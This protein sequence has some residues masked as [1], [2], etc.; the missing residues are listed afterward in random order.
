[1]KPLLLPVC[2]FLFITAYAQSSDFIVVKKNGQNFKSFFKGAYATFQI[3]KNEWIASR[4]ADIKN[5]SIF[6]REVMVRQVATPWGVPKLDTMTTSLRKIHYHDITAVP[7]RNESF[8]FIKDGTLLMMG[9]GGYMLLNIV[10]G[11]YLHYA[12][13]G[14]ENLP[15]LLVATGVFGT[16][17]LLKKLRKPYLLTGKKYRVEYIRMNNE[18]AVLQ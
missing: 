3:N 5:D 17:L 18:A 7:R 1:M 9:G 16:G 4:I 10:N 2:F 11:S 8:T 15:G 12:I 13:L 6:F 14:K